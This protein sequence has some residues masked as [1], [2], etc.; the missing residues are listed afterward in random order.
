[1]DSFYFL[2]NSDSIQMYFF[3]KTLSER[4]AIQ[5]QKSLNLFVCFENLLVWMNCN[6]QMLAQF[7]KPHFF[8]RFGLLGDL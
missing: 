5:F 3:Q 8:M 7:D 1:M 4:E 6:F 2:M